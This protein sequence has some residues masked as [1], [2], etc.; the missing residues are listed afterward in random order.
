MH[1]RPTEQPE[2]E[3]IRPEQPSPFFAPIDLRAVQ[4]TILNREL[5]FTRCTAGI[6]RH[7]AR[8]FPGDCML[9]RPAK[10]F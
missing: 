2:L 7:T 3:P 8:T 5:N 4:K 10:L 9:G 6:E 1:A